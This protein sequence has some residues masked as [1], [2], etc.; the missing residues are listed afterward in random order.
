MKAAIPYNDCSEFCSRPRSVGASMTTRF[1]PGEALSISGLKVRW[2]PSRASA[3]CARH[4]FSDT[5]QVY[6]ICRKIQDL[7]DEPEGK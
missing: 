6:K 1:Y 5:I 3:T 7:G 4:V 2:S